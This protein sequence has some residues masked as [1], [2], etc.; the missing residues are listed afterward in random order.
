MLTGLVDDDVLKTD[1]GRKERTERIWSVF[2]TY[3]NK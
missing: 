1:W 2:H 3:I